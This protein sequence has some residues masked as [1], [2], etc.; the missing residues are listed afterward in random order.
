MGWLR[1]W[2]AVVTF[3]ALVRNHTTVITM[4]PSRKTV[5]LELSNMT[6]SAPPVSCSEWMEYA[7]RRINIRSSRASWCSNPKI[8]ILQ[9]FFEDFHWSTHLFSFVSC[10]SPSNTSNS[11]PNSVKRCVDFR[12]LHN[13]FIPRVPQPWFGIWNIRA[14][15]NSAFSHSAICTQPVVLIKDLLVP[16]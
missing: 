6:S 3:R 8:H 15:G 1:D 4:H 7:E 9:G 16:A 10:L 12:P 2:E 13:Q 14:L 11:N 5:D